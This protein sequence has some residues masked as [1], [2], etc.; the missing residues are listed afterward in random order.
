MKELT[1]DGLELGRRDPGREPVDDILVVVDDRRLRL[2]L[3]SFS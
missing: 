3:A 1:L 2:V